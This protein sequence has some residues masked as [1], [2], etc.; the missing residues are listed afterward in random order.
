MWAMADN[1][2]RDLVGHFYN[3]VGSS[4]DGDLERVPHCKRSVKALWD[5]VQELRRK[6]GMTLA[7]LGKLCTLWSMTDRQLVL[8]SVGGW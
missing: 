2:G 4:S 1:D 3:T 7:A 8:V 6:K 5:A